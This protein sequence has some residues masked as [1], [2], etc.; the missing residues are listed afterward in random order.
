MAHIGIDARYLENEHTGVG[1]YT[2]NLLRALLARDT[3]NTYAIFVHRDYAGELF[4]SPRAT[5]I[6]VPHA[7]ISL[8][9]LT[10][11]TSQVR[12]LRLDLW[13]AHFPVTPLFPGT[14]CVV[15]VHDLQPLRVPALAGGRPLPLRL[16]YRL[17]YPLAYRVT[18][19]RA[20]AILA[21]SAST[22]NDLEEVLGIPRERVHVVHEALD[23]GLLPADADGPTGRTDPNDRR[24]SR[25]LLYVGATLPHKN[26][27]NMIRGFAQALGQPGLEDLHLVVAGRESRF[28]AAWRTIAR[29]LGI[30]HRVVR[31]GYVAPAELS[32]LYRHAEGLLYVS[33]FEGFGFPPL[34]AMAHG[35]PVIVACHGALP[36]VVG[37]AGLFVHPADVPGIARAICRLVGEPSLRKRLSEAGAKNL[38]RYSWDRAASQTLEVYRRI[39]REKAERP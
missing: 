14:P 25:Y 22:R 5:Y 11:M 2:Y 19:S 23:D 38:R 31:V 39:L 16:A 13:H 29:G 20:R 33:R 12:R 17:F 26:L 30:E 9:S 3:D 34:E 24:P 32:S 7:P 15:T 8:A 37:P 21:V 36:E 35:L 10:T 27:G 6:R 28:E 1:R 4:A 18:L